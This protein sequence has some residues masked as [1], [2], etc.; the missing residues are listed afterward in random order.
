[1]GTYCKHCSERIVKTSDDDYANWR[2]KESGS[3]FCKKV[4]HC[5]RTIAEP[6]ETDVSPR[7]A[8]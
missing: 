5:P 8:E 6:R 2:H 3:M 1:M 7:R 4:K